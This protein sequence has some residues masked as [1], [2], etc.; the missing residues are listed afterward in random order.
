MRALAAV[1]VTLIFAWAA[2][3]KLVSRRAWVEFES[4]F[5]SWG[6]SS[7]R[8]W[9]AAAVTGVAVDAL[10]ALAPL[11]L[12]H[13]GLGLVLT[14]TLLTV[15]AVALAARSR[16]TSAPCHCFGSISQGTSAGFHVGAN[17]AVAGVGV[18]GALNVWPLATIGDALF[19]IVAGVLLAGA[20]V[21]GGWLLGTDL[22]VST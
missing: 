5:V 20:A 2:G 22:R 4:S 6:L 16:R 15:F 9:Q 11:L 14:S 13:G 1:T 3:S 10:A 12:W 17:L 7:R 18:L 8:S 21:F 19:A